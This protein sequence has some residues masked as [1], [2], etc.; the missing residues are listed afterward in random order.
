MRYRDC[1]GARG[2]MR[3]YTHAPV[4]RPVR[5]GGSARSRASEPPPPGKVEGGL[6]RGWRGGG[7]GLGLTPLPVPQPQEGPQWLH[8][9]DF[10]RLLRESQREV[11]RLQRQIALRNQQEPPPSSRPPGPAAPARAGAPAPGAPGEVSSGARAGVW[12]SVGGGGGGPGISPGMALRAPR[13]R[14]WRAPSTGQGAFPTP[15]ERVARTCAAP[16]PAMPFG[17]RPPQAC[18]PPPLP[19]CQWYG[20]AAN[21]RLPW[22]PPG[23]QPAPPPPAA[24]LARGRP[25]QRPPGPP[26]PALAPRGRRCVRLGSRYGRPSLGARLRQLLSR[27]LG[28]PLR[29]PRA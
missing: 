29:T 14:R 6:R 1:T 8:V 7:P 15:E 13:T 5:R 18:A 26:G 4:T 2:S 24:A 21:P 3:P 25:L 16:T 10:D 17:V 12:A 28:T 20:P 19:R 11:L 9:R 23:A 22:Q 27:G